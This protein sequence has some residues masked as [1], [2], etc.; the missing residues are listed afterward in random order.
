MITI[1]LNLFL[2]GL[3]GLALVYG[4]RLDARL[5]TVRDG[6]VAFAQAVAELDAAAGKARLGLDELRAAADEATD[7]LGGRVVR[8]REA[9]ERLER[10]LARAEAVPEPAVG[11]EGL[12]ALIAEL[13]IDRDPEPKPYENRP[14]RASP[15]RQRYAV[16]EELFST[17][18]GLS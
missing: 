1:G 18:G 3:L 14:R 15:P 10:L 17:P 5:K 6:Q 4:R 9:A 11:K 8:A 7:L 2:I 13:N 16:D 12:A